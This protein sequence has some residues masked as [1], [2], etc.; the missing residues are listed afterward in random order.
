M[1]VEV[2]R[3]LHKN[4]WSVRDN[5]TGRVIDHVDDIHLENTTLVVR[6]AGREKVLREKRKNV[7]AFIKGTPSICS[8]G[9]YMCSY[10][11]DR[12]VY[13]PYRYASFVLEDTE[14]PITQA[15][16]IYLSNQGKVFMGGEE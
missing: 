4:C 12:V 11:F 15:K 10:I 1:E 5:K 13:N 16:Y 9:H 7:H 14:E 2:Y 8:N 6:P 3:N